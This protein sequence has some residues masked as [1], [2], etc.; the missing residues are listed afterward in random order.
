MGISEKIAH[1]D[2]FHVNIYKEGVFWIAY[3][4]SAYYFWLMKGYKPTKKFVKTVKKEI[5]SIGFPQK[6]LNININSNCLIERD[7]DNLKTFLLKEPIDSEAFEKWKMKLT[8]NNT[9]KDT[10]QTP[11]CSLYF[12]SVLMEQIL[13]FP[14]AD[15]TPMECMLFLSELK[16]ELNT[17]GNLR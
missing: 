10:T 15:K 8:L 11:L 6:A 4:H 17:H 2:V 14:L 1:S 13:A 9:T 5:V 7:E 12:E 3:E 16:K